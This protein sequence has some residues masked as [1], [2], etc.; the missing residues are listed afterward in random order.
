VPDADAII[1]RTISTL[2]AQPARTVFL[3]DFDGS[4]SQIVDRPELAR[5][6]PGAVAVL[7]R[8]TAGLGRVGVVS[9]RPLSYLRE[10]LPVAGLTY[11]G[12]YGM[13]HF[14][15]DEIV[16]DPRVLPY[17]DLVGTAVDEL[18]GSLPA[19][20]VELKDGVSV[21]LHWRRCP[22]RQDEIVAVATAVAEKHGLG[23]LPTR[24]AVELRPPVPIDKADAVRTIVDGY[25]VG[26]FAGDD[27]GDLPAFAALD[28]LVA[29][30]SLQAAVRIG[31][32]SSEA[33]PELKAATDFFVDGPAGLVAYLGRVADQIA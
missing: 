17:L 18:R 21:T 13:Q 15:G 24:A 6:L 3:V 29:T 2:T 28:E 32:A 4:L 22:E 11:T 9:G 30:R 12:L 7:E 20:I 31:V 8:L 5:P 1:A 26:A 16:T 14:F 25:D 33:P 19:D 27:T 10:F 23:L